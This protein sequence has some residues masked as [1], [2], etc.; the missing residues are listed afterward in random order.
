LFGTKVIT[1]IL[2]ISGTIIL[3]LGLFLLVTNSI[4]QSSTFGKYGTVSSGSIDGYSACGIGIVFL[5]LSKVFMK[6]HKKER[7]SQNY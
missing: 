3:F 6:I 7:E 4:S 1:V 5:I 2:L